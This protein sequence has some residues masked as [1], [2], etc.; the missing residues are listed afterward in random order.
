LKQRKGEK[1]E[2]T[3]RMNKVVRKNKKR[4]SALSNGLASFFRAK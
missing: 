1:A 3:I 2:D 4:E